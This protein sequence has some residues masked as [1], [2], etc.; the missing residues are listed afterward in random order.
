M[1]I[2]LLLIALA[3]TIPGA[4]AGALAALIVVQCARGK[5]PDAPG[6]STASDHPPI[7]PDIERLAQSW[8][9]RHGRPESAGV[10][11]AKLQ[12]LSDVAA[13]RGWRK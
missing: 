3:L 13:R 2:D 8:A 10:I 4:L 12:T 6:E 1:T 5:A 7:D 9:A 11:A